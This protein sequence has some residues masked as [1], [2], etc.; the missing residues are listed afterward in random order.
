MN[1]IGWKVF[2]CS[3][4]HHPDLCLFI[5]IQLAPNKNKRVAPRNICDAQWKSHIFPTVTRQDLQLQLCPSW[6]FANLKKNSDVTS[7]GTN[8]NQGAYSIPNQV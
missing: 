1:V 6:R 3:Q 7:L 2:L 5:W 8:Y 4:A